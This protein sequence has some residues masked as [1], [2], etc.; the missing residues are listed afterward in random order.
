MA[1]AWVG[2]FMMAGINTKAVHRTNFL[3]VT[4]G[5]RA[6]STDEMQML[7]GTAVRERR[8]HGWLQFRRGRPT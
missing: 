7:D 6:S 1:G 2:P 5:A 4:R 8:R 3:P